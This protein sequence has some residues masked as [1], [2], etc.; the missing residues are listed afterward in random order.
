MNVEHTR[1]NEEFKLANTKLKRSLFFVFF[2]FVLCYIGIN[3][4][5]CVY[6][7]TQAHTHVHIHIHICTFLLILLN[8]IACSGFLPASVLMSKVSLEQ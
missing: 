4:H 7:H 2:E 8:L 1:M 3:T 5:V 6:T